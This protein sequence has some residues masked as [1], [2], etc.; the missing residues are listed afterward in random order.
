MYLTLMDWNIILNENFVSVSFNDII[1]FFC[2]MKK[3]QVRI[4]LNTGGETIIYSCYYPK[5]YMEKYNIIYT[6]I[7]FGHAPFRV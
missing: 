3:L 1:L 4:K 7:L 6:S 2:L 5:W